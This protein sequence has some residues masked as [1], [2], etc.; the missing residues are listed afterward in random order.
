MVDLIYFFFGG[1]IV[2]FWAFIFAL[3][4]TKLLNKNT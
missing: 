4:E 2:I 1:L 3:I